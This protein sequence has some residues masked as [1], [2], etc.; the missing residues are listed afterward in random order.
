VKY[1]MRCEISLTRAGTSDAD[2]P[3]WLLRK[4][5]D[6][7]LSWRLVCRHETQSSKTCFRYLWDE[8]NCPRYGQKMTRGVA[9]RDDQDISALWPVLFLLFVY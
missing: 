9:R 1:Q 7:W 2:N 3:V 4:H 6:H 8:T 5:V